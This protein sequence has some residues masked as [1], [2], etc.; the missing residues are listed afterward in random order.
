[1]RPA[2]AT[3]AGTK[4]EERLYDALRRLHLTDFEKQPG[5]VAGRPDA[6]FRHTKPRPVA[7]YVDGCFFHGCPVPGHFRPSA[8]VGGPRAHRLTREG[9]AMQ[10]L[11]D[12]RIRRALTAAGTLVLA[13]WEHDVNADPDRC[14]AVI[15]AAV[16]AG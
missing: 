10:R 4:P 9:A 16:K 12:S 2:P 11:T 3:K 1:M 7:V 13:F 5:D 8:D 14:A 6:Y 15:A